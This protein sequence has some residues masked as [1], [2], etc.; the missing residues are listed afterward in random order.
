MYVQVSHCSYMYV[1]VYESVHT[2]SMNTVM[3][4]YTFIYAVLRLDSFET[5][6]IESFWLTYANLQIDY[7]NICMYIHMSDK[8]KYIHIHIHTYPCIN[9]YTYIHIHIHTYTYIYIIFT[10]G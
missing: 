3:K 6:L 8:Y 1:Y 5:T 9:S 7:V 4:L 2:S 10:H